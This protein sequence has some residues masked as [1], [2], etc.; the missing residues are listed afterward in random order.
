MIDLRTADLKLD[1]I[2]RNIEGLNQWKEARKKRSLPCAALDGATKLLSEYKKV[3][4]NVRAKL[5]D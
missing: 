1:E 4:I 5:T 3:I 2:D